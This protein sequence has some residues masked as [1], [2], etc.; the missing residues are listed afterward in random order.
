M[1]PIRPILAGLAFIPWLAAPLTAAV[2]NATYNSASFVPVTSA[3]YTATGSTVNI[4][5]NYAPATG[6]ELTVVRNTGLS[7]INGTFGNLA[8][9]QK[10]ALPYGGI[11]YE[12]VANYYGGSGN[13]L[14]LV[15]ANNRAFS[16]GQNSSG[17]LGDNTTTQRNV[18]VAVDT[19]SGVLAGKTV[20]A[21]AA[22]TYHSLA[23]CSDGTVAAWGGNYAGQIGD[24]TTTDCLVPVAVNTA[25]GV[26]ALYGKTVVA[27]AAG[28]YHSL[29]LCSDGSVA[30]WGGNYE[31]QIG[32]NTTTDRL[33]P[34]AVNTAAGVSALSGKTVVAVAAGSEHSLALCSDGTVAA[35]GSNGWAQLGDNTTTDRLV[36][37][38]VSTAAGVSAL[39]GKTV[40]AVAAGWG[41]SLALCSDGTVNAWGSNDG[42][43]LGDNTTTC[44]LVPVAVNTASGV[45]AL[46][47]RTVVA[48]AA[49]GSHWGWS[50][51]L[52]LCSDGTVAAWGANYAG[53]IG[54]NTTTDRLAPVEVNRAS[55]ASALDG[56]TVV[57]IS[58][59]G[60]HSV[61]LCSEGTVAAWGGNYSGQ[62]G[63]NTTTDHIVPVA[64]DTTPLAA[65][66]RFTRAIAG[67]FGDSMTGGSHT[68]ALASVPY[69]AVIDLTGNG[70]S[71]ADGS[72]TP[73][74][75]NHTD[76]GSLAVGGGTVVR[77]FTI[78][79]TGTL[80]LN[81]TGTPKV[82]VGG[83]HAADFTVTQ[84]PASPVPRGGSTTF[85]VTF[86]PGA[87]WLRTATLS[88]AND[89]PDKN[90][91]DFAI[92]GAETGGGTLA[93]TF[94]TGSEVPLTINGFTATGSTVNLVLNY[95]PATGTELTVVRNTGLSFIDG[96]FGNLAQGQK[97]LLPYGG[98]T[99]EFVANYYGGS[100]NDLVLVWANSRAFAWGLNS[101]GQLGDNTTANRPLPGQVTN[102]GVLAGKTVVAVAAGEFHSLALCSDGTLAAWGSNWLGQLGDNTTADR[103]VPV[104]V[105]TAPGVSALSGKTV[106]A[107]AAGQSRSLALCSDGTVAAW[108][109]NGGGQLGDNSTE[110]RLVPVAVNAASGVSA[111]Y[112]KTVVAVAA[113]GGHSLALCSDGTLAAW[114]WNGYGQLGDNSAA[115]ESNVPVAVSTAPGVSALFGKT[116]VAVAAGNNHSLALCSDGT[117]AAWGYNGDGEL[118]DDS[119]TDSPVPV[120]VSTAPGVS[121]LSGQVVVAVAAGW[122]HNQ[123]LCS[124]GTV[125]AWG[126]NGEGELGDNTTTNR[127]VPVAVSTASGVSALS[128]KTVVAVSAGEYHS[129]A[130]CSDG[131]LAAWGYND[132]GQ[133]GDNTMTQRSAPVAVNAAPLAA[134]E[135]FI[136]VMGG[137][138]AG[139]TLALVAKPYPD[140]N[141]T[142]A[143]AS[144]PNGSSVPSLTNHTDFGG[145][146]AGSGTLVRT[147]TI[148]NAGRL[149]LNL[150]GTPRVAVSGT[151]AA[152][153]TVTQQPASPL[154]P[155][156]STTFQV[157]FA[158]GG[159]WLLRTATL[160]IASD[161]PYENPFRFAI[162]GTGAET[163][164]VTYNT[165]S[166][167]P[168]AV[169]AFAPTGS[170]VNLVLNHAP[171]TGTELTVVRNTGLSF[172]TGT[173]DNLAQGQR[174]ALPYGGITYEFVANYYGGTGNDL[175]LV[176]A[177][178]RPFAWGMND[179]G[180][181]G[182]NTTTQR[183]M[184]VA[185]EMASGVLSGKTVVA[186]STGYWHSLALCS[187]GTVAAWG[188]N[189]DGQLGDNTTTDR[190]VPV[191]VN[192]ASGV[193]ALHGKTVVAVAAGAY[194]SLALCS[195]GTV[196]AWG[197]N[198]LSQ[199]GDDTATG[200]IVPV[201]VSTAPGVSALSGRKVVALAS[202][203]FHSL[204]L[205]SDGTV[206]AWGNNGNGQL[207]DNTT[208][209]RGVPVA[210]NA[211]SD[212]SALSGRTVV[213]V[214]TGRYHSLALC[215]D[216]TVAAWGYN[217]DGQI[218]D[219]TTTDRLVPVAVNT[220]SGVS[221]LHGK[222]VAAVAA[223]SYHS[224]ALCSDGTMAA[225]GDNGAGQIGDTSTIQRRVPVAV[226]TVE[227]GSALSGRIVVEVAAGVAHSLALCSDGTMAA[228]GDNEY[229]ELGDN[230]TTHR[231]EP[232]AVDTAPL[233]E[234]ERFAQVMG[235]SSAF[236]TLALVAV[237]YHRE[238][239]IAGSGVSIPDGST[240]PGPANHTDFGSVAVG[241]G[242]VTR[243]F[244]IR[245]TGTLP[246]NLT[247]TPRVAVGG[248]HAADFTVTQQPSSP[249]GPGASTSF[250]V[251]FAPGAL[252][253]RT[254]TLGIANDDPN[255]NSYD[256]AV[257]GAGTGG[258]TLAATFNS[259][260]EVPLTIN[261]FTATGST[262]NLLLNHAPATGTELTVVRNTGTAF[263][264]GT[265]GNLAQGQ[266]VS[267]PYG[268]STYEFVANYFGG[269]GNDLVLVWANS[270]PFAWGYNQAGQLG[271]N[272]TTNRNLPVE[273][274]RSGVLAG[275]T[276]LAVAPGGSH[277]LALCSDGTVAAWGANWSGQL[278]DN[279]TTDRLVPVAV[280]TAPGVSALY[281]KTVVAVAAGGAHSLALCSDGTVAAWGSND[282]GQLGDNTTTQRNV[283]VVVNTASGVSALYGKTV[284]AVA[285]SDAHSLALCSDGTVVAWG[286]NSSG[287][288]GDNTRTD[289]IVPVEVSTASGVSA[290]SGRTVLAV[291][292]GGDRSLALCSDGTVVAWGYN[293]SGQLG[294]N[295]T[296]QRNVPVAVSTAP[297]VSALSGKTVI[298]IAAGYWHTLAMCS[299]GTVVAW[300]YNSAGALGDNTTTQ[301]NAPVAVDT[302]PGVSALHGKTVINV[303]AGGDHSLALCSDGTMAAWGY[304]TYGQIGDNTTTQR[305]VPVAVD[306]TPIAAGE[307]FTRVMGGSSAS[308][309]LALMAAP[310]APDI[311]LTG[312]GSSIPDGSSAPGLTNHTDF[313]SVTAGSGTVVRTFTLLNTGVLPLNLTSTPKVAVGGTHAADFTV[314]QQPD[315]PLAP[316]A[317][318][319]FQVT[320]APGAAWLR[321]AT[322]SIA[323]DDPDED[324]YGFAIQGTGTGA[325]A[326]TFNTGSEVP[327]TSSAFTATGST[328]NIS[329][330][331]APATATELTVVRNTGTAF[332]NGTFGN[333]A[334]GQKV[335]LPY[336]GITYEF[337]ANY[338]GGSGNDLVLVWA[339]NRIFAWG[340]NFDGELGDNTATQR[341]VPVAVSTS[342]VLAGK[343]VIAV[344]A[345]G[346][347][348]LALCSDGTLAA[349]GRNDS[350]QLGD[351][352]T[353][354]R[355]VPVAVNTASGLSALYGKTVIAV[356]AGGSHSLALCSDGTVAAWGNNWSGQ[357]GGNLVNQQ[358]VP[359]AVSTSD[360]LAGKTVIA[361]A[362]GGSHSLALCSDGTLAAWGRND[363]G[364]LGDNT[365][366][367]RKV[368]V[369]VNTAPGVS[370]LHGRTVLAVAAGNWHSLAL[371]SDGTLAAWGYN[372]PA[373]SATIPPFSAVRRWQST[374]FRASRC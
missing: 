33:V 211:A 294:D 258:G 148:L 311:N 271:D 372:G 275:K 297:G 1:K 362:A 73:V 223:G 111:L 257:Q 188:N 147:F 80:P 79:N 250:Q 286:A 100:G 92:Q 125:A 308:H 166:E 354:Q 51:S 333:L 103:L 220:A 45:S 6:T 274:Q 355:N 122:G 138:Y 177:N 46:C 106:V 263:I 240:T 318:T 298:A 246:L 272:T 289:R 200:S 198:W 213:G 323:S 288:L 255:E 134:R 280:S 365:T 149:P 301:R 156:A 252:W 237:P 293:A 34:V 48:V 261:G 76:F 172:I 62:L 179:S 334:Q 129:L 60:S 42:G 36:P 162:Q 16:W 142:G 5:L 337:V 75:S 41:H 340:R 231:P 324:Q 173:F 267:L 113:G 116:V 119:T 37:V 94:N 131:T 182:D 165:G 178:N 369:A 44:R 168:L 28:T 222:T 232:V 184:P 331:Y 38:A 163:L 256:F 120:A 205:C 335:L 342:D 8:Q 170:T 105:N 229:G 93:A 164:A 186:V 201:A 143:G 296:T 56:K 283:P 352:T 243:T 343:T 67:G 159:A 10:V 347:H 171:A 7:F 371:C 151:H 89:D 141:L 126:Y 356:A 314:T 299:D 81:L 69:R 239:E 300:G 43:Q 174:I 199:L 32:D 227:G 161:H 336:G 254:A 185:V 358:S 52:A 68:L 31:G 70:A 208:T 59:G 102:A 4:V 195:D 321:T 109:G 265:F 82:A 30:A 373:S 366:T 135:R 176:W 25:S 270:R 108:G 137:S 204:A 15:W 203:G 123:A 3:G 316:G 47:G 175:V 39:S 114:G 353:T 346:S 124:D 193:S 86:D 84:Q 330:N 183:N 245:N 27:V 217:G 104:A 112:G 230:T 49:S 306:T 196:A 154:A 63:D 58:A 332:I 57:G 21:V 167:V 281:G 361:V 345:G 234:G 180:Q 128:G 181:I 160:S 278:G 338:Y 216:G 317:S 17:Q 187:D 367:Q 348:S 23:L 305:N 153:F 287:Q 295:T 235:G 273:V 12:F 107:V 304:N 268:G 26:S 144:I 247:G 169:N 139:H 292:A 132:G 279:T 236:H 96:T 77:T 11:T 65:G 61:A 88:I 64:V 50:H 91:Y 35:W 225:W 351:N 221:A 207:G 341:N 315:S 326:A 136:R 310:S 319:T 224:L 155:G 150:T 90:P 368:P 95:A 115:W 66:E 248:T 357:L 121:A 350:G 133:L 101:Y 370:A 309:S 344:A 285:A 140:I 360:V 262:V 363:Y 249:V 206:A 328:V 218:G 194:H 313:G 71:I 118:G 87:A 117:V 110:D 266:R 130:L 219:N 291:A 364:Q 264:N 303:A 374:R 253:L 244:T 190:L 145:V 158:P 215:S 312:N 189:G 233:A 251:T 307:R 276:V 209:L 339:N 14:V 191:A 97:I 146:T 157:T 19:A 238:I 241:S 18:P 9:G 78:R 214:A 40:V 259:G 54:D 72:S 242:T 349:W 99:Y 98:T 29:A 322:L 212:V 74:P 83:T 325:L 20:V 85:Q 2:V 226:S 320:F 277:S 302:A 24:N 260:S 202:G 329:L 282:Y 290:L 127:H 22:G 284:V 359:V 55:G 53:Q 13:D 197:G 192:T 327:L 228:W 269:S 152:H 210:V